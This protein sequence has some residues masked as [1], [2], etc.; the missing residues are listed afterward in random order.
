METLD[1]LGLSKYMARSFLLPLGAMIF[2]FVLA[3]NCTPE[4]W[5][6]L[7]A[8]GALITGCAGIFNLNEAFK[9]WALKSLPDKK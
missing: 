2:I 5:N 9:T 8:P 1:K 7:W 6:L 3:Y 4:Q